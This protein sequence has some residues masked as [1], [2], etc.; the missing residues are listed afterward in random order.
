MTG[1][2]YQV[3]YIVNVDAANAQSAINAFK[4]AV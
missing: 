1:Q 3:N 2:T 4:R